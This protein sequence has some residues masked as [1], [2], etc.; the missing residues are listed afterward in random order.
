MRELSST[1]SVTTRVCV[2]GCLRS[3]EPSRP[4]Q[5]FFEPSCRKSNWENRWLRRK[6]A[7]GARS[8]ANASERISLRVY[9]RTRIQPGS[10]RTMLRRIAQLS[11]DFFLRLAD[12][13]RRTKSGEAAN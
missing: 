12:G 7:K 4:W 11:P 13:L 8:A 10:I 1:A 5:K 3:F 6:P 9:T 2:C